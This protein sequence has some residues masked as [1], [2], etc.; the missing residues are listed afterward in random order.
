MKKKRNKKRRDKKRDPRNA[1]AHQ[2]TLATM[3][4]LDRLRETFR[5]RL[6]SLMS[7]SRVL[8]S[9]EGREH[10]IDL[11]LLTSALAAAN[12]EMQE[13]LLEGEL[14][15]EQRLEGELSEE[16]VRAIVKRME[17]AALGTSH[18]R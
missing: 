8:L 2:D 14:S 7:E 11:T 10:P 3:D 6:A 15:E 12:H 18:R 5:E 16:Q 4:K 17:V 9:H 1:R 13:Q